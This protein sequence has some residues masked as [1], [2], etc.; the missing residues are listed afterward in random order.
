[1]EVG[2]LEGFK[3]YI[4]EGTISTIAAFSFI[5]LLSTSFEN[6]K[7]FKDGLI[8]VEGK[9]IKK[10][11]KLPIFT[12]IAR[13]IKILFQRFVPNK[14]YLAVLIAMYLLKKEE[15]MDDYEQIVKEELD[16]SL[17]EEESQKLIKIL[18]EVK[19]LI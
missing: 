11:P 5:K 4:N 19:E 2:V 3:N 6:W 9:I 18:A 17:T 7:V 12:N 14:K 13:K 15:V 10:T 16:K 8:D 1:M